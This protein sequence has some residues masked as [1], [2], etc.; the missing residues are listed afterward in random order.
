MLK[1]LIIGLCLLSFSVASFAVEA[2]DELVKRTAEDVLTIV[3]ADK[4][5]QV[6]IKKSCLR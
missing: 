1:R 5:I 3:K 2:P 4:D 6:A